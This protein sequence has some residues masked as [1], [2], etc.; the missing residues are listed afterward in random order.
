MRTLDSYCNSHPR[1]KLIK[2]KLPF[3][4]TVQDGMPTIHIDLAVKFLLVIQRDFK[5]HLVDLHCT[6]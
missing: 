4:L 2:K 5:F 3:L 1:Q 6:I